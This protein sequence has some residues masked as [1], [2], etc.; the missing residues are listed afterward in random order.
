LEHTGSPI[1]LDV[2]EGGF[3]SLALMLNPDA[4]TNGDGEEDGNNN[5]SQQPKIQHFPLEV[6]VF[7]RLPIFGS[8]QTNAEAGG[9]DEEDMDEEDAPANEQVAK[10][11]K[12]YGILDRCFLADAIRDLL[13][14]HE[15][16]V[17]AIGQ[18]RGSAK[19][20]AEQLWSL[21]YVYASTN[22]SNHDASSPPGG[23]EYGI[24][25]ALLSLILQSSSNSTFRQIFL[26][27]V[28]LELTRLQPSYVSPTLALAVSNLFQDYIP[29]L[30]PTARRNLSCWLAFH[31]VNTDYQWPA[32]YWTH[33]QTYIASDNNQIQS[34][35][36]FVKT[37]LSFLV[38]NV[39]NP[40]AVAR[41][42]IPSDCQE[43]AS[44][45]LPP[46]PAQDSSSDGDV[47]ESFEKDVRTR[48][49]DNDEHPESLKGHITG[50]E[51]SGTLANVQS[52]GSF[53]MTLAWCRS[54]IVLKTLL[55]PLER[56]HQR[57]LQKI[58]DSHGGAEDDNAMDEDDDFSEDTLAV[59]QEVLSRYGPVLASAISK[60][61]EVL[62]GS[63]TDNSL[64]ASFEPYLLDIL[65]KKACFSRSML[66]GCLDCLMQHA[67]IIQS[68]GVL[69]WALGDI[70]GG[71]DDQ[72]QT[73]VVGRWYEF[74][75]LA[76]RVFLAKKIQE[77]KKQ[78]GSAPGGM[79]IDRTGDAGMN[80]DAVDSQEGDNN[81]SKTLA[82]IESLG[83]LLDYVV[84][85]VCTLLV[86]QADHQSGNKLKPKE[87]DLVEGVK[88]CLRSTHALCF[89]ELRKSNENESGVSEREIK[90]C[91]SQ[92]ALAGWKL[93]GVCQEFGSSH[94]VNVLS[95]C[96]A[97]V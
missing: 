30:V 7:G 39:N 96:L 53:K 63:A 43:L 28:L 22:N 2:P 61:K 64:V 52:D 42:C 24:V 9:D 48:I 8:P 46:L 51:L 37:T 73:H 20:V 59:L 65:D 5:S 86:E 60:D 79:V 54:G 72:Q 36:I 14:C 87:V 71:N 85:R 16:T 55:Q 75:N 57:L 67:D 32:A 62:E 97:T 18:E 50:D 56:E 89:S 83:P 81:A 31:L 33:W 88:S 19:S 13:C 91:L 10:Y 78:E 58:Q 44:L 12:E 93:S 25:E 17:S 47:V 45:L 35:G 41:D 92:S 70:P 29:A 80:E 90:D 76:I 68:S 34:R 82:V 38:E 94:A 66:E 15:S 23:L 74:A 4:F 77:I 21:A 27:R 1:A 26:S 69:R 3:K 84:R 11:M 40:V 6:V 49:W 95:N